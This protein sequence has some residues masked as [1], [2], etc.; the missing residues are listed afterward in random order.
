PALDLNWSDAKDWKETSRYDD[1]MES[2][3]RLLYNAVTHEPDGVMRWIRQ[4]DKARHY[5][6]EAIALTH[7]ASEKKLLQQKIMQC[8]S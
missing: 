5:F 4:F 6:L 8:C 2:D 3:A 7:A 1:R